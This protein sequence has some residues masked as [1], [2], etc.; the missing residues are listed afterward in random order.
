MK[1]ETYA[2]ILDHLKKKYK[3]RIIPIVSEHS[4]DIDHRG[5][6]ILFDVVNIDSVGIT[7]S[8]HKAAIMLVIELGNPMLL[9]KLYHIFESIK[10]E[11]DTNRLN[12]IMKEA[13]K[14]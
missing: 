8:A 14:L 3:F 9:D 5:A 12:A 4:N 6:H 11:D 7:I 13:D 1:Y 2:I 10:H